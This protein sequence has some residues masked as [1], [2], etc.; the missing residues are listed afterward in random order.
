VRKINHQKS[1]SHLFYEAFEKLAKERFLE[2]EREAKARFLSLSVHAVHRVGRV[3]IGQKA[4]FIGVLAA[5]RLEAFLAA[6]FLIDELKKSVP[7]WKQE[8]YEDNTAIFDQG[9]CECGSADNEIAYLPVKE[10]L[11]AGSYHTDTLRAAS[12]LLI[13]A[14]GLGCPLAIN[15]SALFIKELHIADGDLVSES[16]LARQYIFSPKDLGKNKAEVVSSFLRERFSNTSFSAWPRFVDK[17]SLE[18]MLVKFDLIIDSS[19]CALTK[20]MTSLLSLK[21]ARPYIAASV[22]QEEGELLTL[23]DKEDG[24]FSCFRS[25]DGEELNCRTTGVFTHACS[26]VAAQVVAKS[27][28]ILGQRPKTKGS[29]K[30]INADGQSREIAISKDPNCR[31]CQKH[32]PILLRTYDDQL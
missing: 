10:A 32:S 9:L 4:V 18:S 19:D 5:H 6:R 24:C 11:I 17:A 29:L 26:M 23:I 20:T 2:L 8:F 15:L 12:V 14:G 27:L 1:V 25:I 31:H 30:I 13:G 21:A 28:H 3:E 22:F 7:I 16:N